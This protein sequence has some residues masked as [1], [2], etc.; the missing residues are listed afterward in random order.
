MSGV[1]FSAFGLTILDAK[2]NEVLSA[3]KACSNVCILTACLLTAYLFSF[4][5][6]LD[7]VAA[8]CLIAAEFI[9]CFEVLN[10]LL[11]AAL[12]LYLKVRK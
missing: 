4:S 3:T 2:G 1:K 11:Y 12:S 9:I 6:A 8:F 10:A 5:W 7:G